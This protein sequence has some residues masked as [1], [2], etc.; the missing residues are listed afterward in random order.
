MHNKA[1]EI[2]LAD[3]ITSLIGSRLSS[4]KDALDRE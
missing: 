3:A 1:Y 4:P 2:R